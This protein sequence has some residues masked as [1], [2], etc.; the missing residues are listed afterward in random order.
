MAVKQYPHLYTNFF[1]FSFSSLLINTVTNTYFVDWVPMTTRSNL[2]SWLV[3]GQDSKS[4]SS[5]DAPGPREPLPAT[6]CLEE[7]KFT[8]KTQKNEVV[9]FQI[10][11]KA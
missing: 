10:S 5:K 7:L 1:V 8:N 6:P 4:L 2:K 9:Y 3:E 11:I